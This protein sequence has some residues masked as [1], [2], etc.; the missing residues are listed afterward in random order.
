MGLYLGFTFRVPAR[1]GRDDRR[2]AL[3]DYAEGIVGSFVAP[4][5]SIR[6]YKMSDFNIDMVTPGKVTLRLYE[7]TGDERC[8]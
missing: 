8:E 7:R 6:T 5:G 3:R 4:D 1:F 2:H